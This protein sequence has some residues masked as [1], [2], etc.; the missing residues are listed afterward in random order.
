VAI[1][2]GSGAD[3]M[4]AMMAP[5]RWTLDYA[6]VIFTMWRMMMAPGLSG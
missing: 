1:L 4:A 5:A 6:G 3:D 2:F